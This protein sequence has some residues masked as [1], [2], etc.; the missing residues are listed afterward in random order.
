MHRAIQP[1]PSPLAKGIFGY[2][3]RRLGVLARSFRCTVSKPWLRRAA[4][5][6]LQRLSAR[7]R[8]DIGLEP[9]EIEGLVDDML[10]AKQRDE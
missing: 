3:L 5:H 10:S 8:R 4:I 7:E 1:P 6:E 9:Y 2:A